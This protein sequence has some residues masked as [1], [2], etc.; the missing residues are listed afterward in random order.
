MPETVGEVREGRDASCGCIRPHRRGFVPPTTLAAARAALHLPRVLRVVSF[1]VLQGLIGVGQAMAHGAYP[2]A[3]EVIPGTPARGDFLLRTTF[4]LVVSGDVGHKLICEELF[5]ESPTAAV[6]LGDGTYLV[7]GSAGLH[8]SDDGCSWDELGEPVRD[9]FV[10]R[11]LTDPAAPST[12]WI[13]TYTW[14]GSN[15]L[16]RSDDSGRTWTLEVAA[17][18]SVRVRDA[19]RDGKGQW[20]LSERRDDGP[21]LRRSDGAEWL[22]PVAI[23][24]DTVRLLHVEGGAAYV[25]DLGPE[26]DRLLRLGADGQ[27]A[28]LA[29]PQGDIAGFVHASDQWWLAVQGVGL[30]HAADPAG[31]W[32]AVDG[33]PA[34]RCLAYDGADLWRCLD[35]YDEGGF[36]WMGPPGEVGAAVVTPASIDALH[37]CPSDSDLALACSGLWEGIAFQLGLGPGTS[38]EPDPQDADP[39]GC[40]VSTGPA[41]ASACALLL[42][43]LRRR[44][45]TAPRERRAGRSRSLVVVAAFLVATLGA[46]ATGDGPSMTLISPEEGA[47]VCGDPLEVVVEV[48]NFQLTDEIG[49]GGDLGRGHVHATMNGQDAG[50]Y[51]VEEFDLDG[52]W[53]AGEWRLQLSLAGIDHNDVEPYVGQWAYLTVDPEQCP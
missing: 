6:R 2:E 35:G 31:P 25:V 47:V 33:Q 4:G 16:F 8:R 24:T 29:E 53:E 1:I 23:S 22:V 38:V 17:G 49:V 20:F 30:L 37:Q 41:S 12:A 43:W 9:A 40:G 39:A 15:G 7:G 48:E 32:T 26:F 11:I 28:V 36:L 5:S 34:P 46:C 42:P 27:W 10:T 18:E 21:W 14:N 3:L 45:A 44:R 52:S 50:Q 13:A 19:A 51:V